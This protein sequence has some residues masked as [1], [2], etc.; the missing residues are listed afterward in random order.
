M[1]ILSIIYF[2]YTHQI[3]EPP[4]WDKNLYKSTK[5]L[6]K[7]YKSKKKVTKAKLKFT[8]VIKSLQKQL[9]KFIV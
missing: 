5:S 9:K 6:Q 7:H 3:V 1:G 4:P 2:L 8:Q